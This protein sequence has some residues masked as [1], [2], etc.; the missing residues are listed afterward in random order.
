MKGQGTLLDPMP[1]VSKQK[2]KEICELLMQGNAIKRICLDKAMPSYMTFL[3]HVQEDEEAHEEYQRAQ[4][5]RAETMWDDIHELVVQPLPDDKQLANAEV[6]RRRLQADMMEKRI[7]QM[8][9]RGVT[10]KAEN[11]HSSGTISITWAGGDVF[12]EEG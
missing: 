9:S 8:A 11:K 4:A 10:N 1:R 6:Q 12:A 3:R 2:M 5:I 7:R